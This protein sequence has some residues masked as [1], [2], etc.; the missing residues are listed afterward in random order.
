MAMLLE[1]L[2]VTNAAKIHATGRQ[3]SN[4]SLKDLVNLARHLMEKSLELFDEFNGNFTNNSSL[5]PEL[6]IHNSSTLNETK[7][8]CSLAFMVEALKANMKVQ[9]ELDSNATLLSKLNET[10][11]HVTN[12]NF[13]ASECFNAKCPE[14]PKLPKMPEYT[15]GKKQWGHSLL[16]SAEDYLKWLHKILPSKTKEVKKKKVYFKI[17][18]QRQYLRGA[19]HHL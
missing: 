8:L 13:K 18:A 7:V 2:A 5:F 17:I 14:V 6:Q 12:L 3:C 15:F 1:G 4:T 10:I 11:T 16:K 9:I 19:M